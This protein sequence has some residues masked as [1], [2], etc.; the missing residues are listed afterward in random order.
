MT[1]LCGVV[2][3]VVCFDVVLVDVD[4]V[5]VEDE[6]VEDDVDGSFLKLKMK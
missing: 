2:V 3:L 6:E 5:V 1:G 4:L